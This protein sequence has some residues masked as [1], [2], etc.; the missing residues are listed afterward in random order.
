MSWND[1][2]MAERAKY[3]QLSVKSGVTSL[4]TIRDTYNSYARGGT[5]NKF[6]DGGG[7]DEYTPST[8]AGWA[9]QLFT[10]DNT[11]A[12]YADISSSTFNIGS[13]AIPVVGNVAGA[14]VSIGDALYDASKL[15]A[16]DLGLSLAGIIPGVGSVKD[17]KNIV[18]A[19]KQAYRNVKTTKTLK[20]VKKTV[21]RNPGKTKVRV[22]VLRPDMRVSRSYPLQLPTSPYFK[23]TGTVGNW[24]DGIQ[25]TDTAV[26]YLYTK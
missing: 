4:D 16:A 15:I 19:S 18:K 26:D 21:T 6:G 17:V 3:I 22:N 5:I 11:K 24:S 7:A 25:D 10:G 14:I 1:L 9:T 13:D 12:A 23:L 8:L 20:A 2:S